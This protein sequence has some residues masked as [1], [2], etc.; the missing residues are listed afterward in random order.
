M[1]TANPDP[2]NLTCDEYDLLHSDF[3]RHARD[4]PSRNALEFLED[5][6]SITTYTFSQLN[7]AANQVAHYL[8]S[9]GLK[10]DEAVPLCLEKLP[11]F[12]ICVLGVLKAGYAFTPIDP[13]LPVQRKLFMLQE[14]GAKVVLATAITSMDLLLPA[15][16]KIIEIEASGLLDSQPLT[17]PKVQNLSPRCLAY[18]LYTS[19]KLLLQ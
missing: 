15:E 13:S 4:N 1:S 2:F 3:E 6:G 12:Y 9:L 10:R 8:L 14:L 7:Q 11:I 16:V 17:N 18:R 19:G 5:S